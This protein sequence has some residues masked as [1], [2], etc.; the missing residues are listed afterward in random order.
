MWTGRPIGAGQTLLID[1]V[2]L[3]TPGNYISLTLGRRTVVCR[4]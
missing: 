2:I 1:Q 3:P 4:V